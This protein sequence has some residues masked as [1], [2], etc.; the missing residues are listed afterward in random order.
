MYSYDK[1]KP[2]SESPYKNVFEKLDSI[3]Y[4]VIWTCEYREMFVH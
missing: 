1:Q 2:I 3:L 4:Y